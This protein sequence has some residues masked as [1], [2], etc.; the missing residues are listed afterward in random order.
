MLVEGVGDGR[1]IGGG[2]RKGL[3]GQPPAGFAA[4]SAVGGLQF[5]NQGGIIGHAGDDGHVFKVLGGGADHRGA[6]DVDVFDE[7]TEG[8]RR[9][10]R[11]SSRRR[12][13]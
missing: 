4:E 10:G 7:M 6:A 1:V 12:R 5:L 3:P 2:E 11:R 8:R 9:A 13:G